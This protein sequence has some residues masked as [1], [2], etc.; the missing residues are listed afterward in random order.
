M[1][2][3]LMKLLLAPQSIKIRASKEYK[4]L[5]I[6]INCLE[7]QVTISSAGAIVQVLR[8]EVCD[9]AEVSEET[10]KEGICLCK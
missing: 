8:C 3:V 4:V 1:K 9:G 10:G 2:L 5:F 6:F 7:E